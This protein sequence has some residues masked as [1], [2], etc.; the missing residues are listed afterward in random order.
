MPLAPPPVLPP[1]LTAA[2]RGRLS[3][4]A[5]LDDGVV[6]AA[7]PGDVVAALRL[8]GRY[9]VPVGGPAGRGLAV[10]VDALDEVTVS[11]AGW[12]R[13]GGGVR[14]RPLAEAAA[15]CGLA[16]LVGPT[17]A[18]R[19]ADA[20]TGGGVGP[21][22]RTYGPVSDR[23]RAVEL[24]TGD[25]VLRR[26]TAEGTPE[27]FWGVRGGGAGLGVVT[28]V[29]LDL[30]AAPTVHAG[31]L[32]WAGA[33]A[34]AVLARWR[35][36]SAAL[37]PQAGTTLLLVRPPA[38]PDAVAV[39]FAWTGD[40]ADGADVLDGLR[41]A[42]PPR[43]DDVVVRRPGDLGTAPVPG[44]GVESSLLLDRLPADGADALL[45]AAR[46]TAPRTVELR[47][48]GGAVGWVPE[49]GS[50]LCHRDARLAVRV[51]GGAGA[52]RRA[53]TWA[54]VEELAGLLGPDTGGREPAHGFGPSPD[55]LARTPTPAVRGRLA[56][57]AATTDPHRVLEGA[58]RRPPADRSAG[59][60]GHGPG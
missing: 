1:D 16:P 45:A 43:S 18:G 38:G 22:A 55:V 49:R 28:A 5:R 31:W 32:Q 4:G 15:R 58:G 27:L 14:W 57:L 10:D 11:R 44:D 51:V 7:D 53:A 42:V 60:G 40:P 29:E 50:A 33:D 48:L 21:L 54:C 9:G 47:L 6:T 12:A 2:L 26:V 35:T 52:E 39:R 41:G 37:P 8:A 20:V 34:P 19:V 59:P 17:P 30:L 23:V 24:V 56:A 3:P 36:W 25:G 46:R 13:V